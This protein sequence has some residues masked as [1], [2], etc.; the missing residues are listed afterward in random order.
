MKN[1]DITPLSS[2]DGEDNSRRMAAGFDPASVQTMG[3]MSDPTPR[4]LYFDPQN[5]R[6]HQPPHF[7]PIKRIVWKLS[8]VPELPEFHPL[9][10]RA[11]FVP[12]AD[13]SEISARISAIL[14][15]RSIEAVYDD[16]KAKVKCVTEEGVD[17]RI[18]LYTGRGE[19]HHGIIVEVQRRFGFSNS[20][21]NETQAILDAAVGKTPPPPVSSS[22]PLP[23]PVVSDAEEDDYDPADGASAL[24]MVA[25][26]LNHPGYDST[27]LGLQTLSS[28]TD[29]SKIGNTTARKVANALMQIDN[30]V[31]NKVLSII[32]DSKDDEMYKLRTLAMTI[33]ANVMHT[34]EFKIPQVVLDQIRPVLVRELK[35]ANQNPRLAVQAA[36]CVECLLPADEHGGDLY[37][38]L[39]VAEE[40]GMARHSGLQR[41][42]QACLEKM[43]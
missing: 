34:V 7:P 28:L 38:A 26:M 5:Q 29:S 19:Y 10:Q 17:F 31:G 8:V 39:Q 24:D 25:K 42:A 4:H 37:D 9:E 1:V 21:H 15:E 3:P 20:F 6:K 22:L 12:H 32:L 40:A 13:P 36:R 27:Y 23:P 2:G 16:D 43:H 35:S 41:Q 11:V 30:Q 18:R 14:H 33:L